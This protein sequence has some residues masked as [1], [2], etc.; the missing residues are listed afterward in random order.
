[1]A[2]NWDDILKLSLF[3]MAAI[4]VLS[5]LATAVFGLPVLKGGPV[6]LI[7]LVFGA[8]LLVWNLASKK[9]FDFDKSDII[10]LVL[11]AGIIVSIFIFLPQA[12]P[13]IFST[14]RTDLLSVVGL[15]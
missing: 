10:A 3:G 15:S 2:I 11:V 13:Q 7:L 12:V 1:M 6:I 4:F 14:L 8:I 5:Y 9:N